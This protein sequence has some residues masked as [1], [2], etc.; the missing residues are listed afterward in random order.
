MNSKQ[1]TRTV[2]YLDDAIEELTLFNIRHI[3]PEI[4]FNNIGAA[5]ALLENELRWTEDDKIK[6]LDFNFCDWHGEAD[7]ET[8]DD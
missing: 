8:E 7:E 3:V 4:V 6:E 1:I 2:K 5:I